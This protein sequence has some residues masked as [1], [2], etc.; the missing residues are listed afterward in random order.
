MF[1]LSGVARY[2]FVPMAEAVVFAMLASYL[3][4]RTVVPTMAK[5]LLQEHDDEEIKRKAGE[6]Q[7]ACALS[8][9]LRAGFEKFRIGYLRILT[10][11]VDHAG[12]FLIVFMVFAL[13]GQC[14]SWRHGW[15]RISFPRWTRGSSRF[16]CA[17]G[18]ARALKKRLR[19]A[20][21][22]TPP[23]GEHI[24]AER[25]RHDRRQH[26]TALLGPESLLLDLGAHRTRRC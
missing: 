23:S 11:F 4:S 1:L 8:A 14:S 16:T 26:R 25:N 24:P 15:A 17:P 12:V 7:S 22:L 9:R 3:L 10:L 5:Y 20:I 2:L 21:T 18:P 19:C 6:P 13:S